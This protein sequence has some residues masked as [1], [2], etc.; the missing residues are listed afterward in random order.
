MLIIIASWIYILLLAYCLGVAVQRGLQKLLGIGG[1][2]PRD[3][4][5]TLESGVKTLHFSLTCLTGLMTL[6]FLCM[7]LCLVMPL[8]LASNG[9]ILVITATASWLARDDLRR[10][11][12]ADRSRLQKGKPLVNLIFIAFIFIIARL[13]YDPSSH[14]DDGLYYSTSIRWLQEYGTVKGLANVNPRIAFNSSWHILQANFGFRFL[15]LGLFNDL[16]GLIFLLMLL[17]SVGG[18]NDLLKGDSSWR[19]ALRAFFMLP[20][21]AFHFES[22]SDLM[23]L[24]ANFLSSPTADIPACLLTWMIFV[25]FLTP[26]SESSV[27]TTPLT[28]VLVVLYSAWACT[29]KFSTVPIF[30]LSALPVV[31]LAFSRQDR[32][33][34]HPYRQLAW[35]IGGCVLIAAPW[36][37][38]NI[39]LSGYLLFPFSAIDIFH[40]RWKIPIREVRW[41]E[42]AITA[43]ALGA[44]IDKPFNVPLAVW[45]PRWAAGLDFIRQVI[46]GTAIAATICCVGVGVYAFAKQGKIFFSRYARQI[47]AIVTGIAGILF[48]LVKAPDFR[49]GYG[50]LIIYCMLFLVLACR[51]GL[52]RLLHYLVYPAV[53]F[54]Y[55]IAIFHY[56]NV[57]DR[58][59]LL[60]ARP[61]PYRMPSTMVEARGPGGGT[62]NIVTH[63]DSWNGPLPIANDYEYRDLKPVYLGP[64]IEDGFMSTG[65]PKNH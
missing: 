48:W 33:R 11:L 1:T 27:E 38:R 44:D 31:R 14:F 25:L 5:R 52:E 8:D 45:F 22:T 9:I 39:F 56:D 63:S 23:L 7:V 49:F 54:M 58:L 36:V 61:L 50:F 4:M 21:L 57:W 13:S 24:N 16:N 28:D 18:I 3:G 47:L 51:W 37:L 32:S 62:F 17:Y 6:T 64:R 10:S 43:F 59:D 55:A 19:T 41:H 29:I 53:I 2:G 12:A 35:V 34:S 65:R 46:L 40:V 60:F 15:N 20:L 30:L 42:N 26:T